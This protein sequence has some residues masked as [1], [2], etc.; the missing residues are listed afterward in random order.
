MVHGLRNLDGRPTKSEKSS[1]IVGAAR[2]GE[3]EICI[4]AALSFLQERHTDPNDGHALMVIAA[5][6]GALAKR[7][8][9]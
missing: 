1:R 8:L 3:M 9:D 6:R 4:R 5:L 2:I 7:E